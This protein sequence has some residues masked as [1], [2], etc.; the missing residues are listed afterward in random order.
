MITKKNFFFNRL[1]MRHEM[2]RI[3]S[4]DHNDRSYRSTIFLSSYDDKKYM[5]ED[6]CR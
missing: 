5:P 1:D 2:N 4:K 3:R 6:G